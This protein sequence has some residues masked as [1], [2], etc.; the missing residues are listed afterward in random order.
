MNEMSVEHMVLYR[1]GLASMVMLPLALWHWRF[2]HFTVP[3]LRDLLLSAALGIPVQFLIQFHGLALT[4]VSHAALM[5]GAMPVLLAVAATLFSG[6]RMNRFC[7]TTLW[8]STLGAALVSLGGRH[9]STAQ[10]EPSLAGDLLVLSSLFSSLTWVLMNKKLMK[11]HPPSVITSL[12]ILSGTA[13]LALWVLT[14]WLLHLLLPNMTSAVAAPPVAHLSRTAWMALIASG[15]LCTATTTFLWNLG[16]HRV[17]ASRAGILLNLEPAL[18]SVLG[19]T[20]LGEHLGP[21]AW[22]GGSLILGAA[23]ALTLRSNSPTPET[24]ME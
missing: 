12:T 23:I 7:W 18:G 16:I 2:M 10:G 24:L 13:M 1:F 5:I 20:L 6:E 3:E 15:L 21:L 8:I 14:P 9:G 22:A 11:N 4:T 17:P 19:V